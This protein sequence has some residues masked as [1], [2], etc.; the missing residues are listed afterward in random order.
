MNSSTTRKIV[1]IDMDAFYASVEQR[2]N[3]ALRGKPI[4]V[5][6]GG[7]RGVTTTASYEARQFGVRSAMPG[8]KA[9]QL[10]PEL[11]F[12]PPRF[13][14]YQEVSRQVRA[15]FAKYTDLI[16]PLSLDEA[17]LDVTVNKKN[18]P[19]GMDVAKAIMKQVEEETQLTCSAGV[20]YCKFLAKVASGFKKPN[21]LTIIRPKDAEAFLE[22]LPVKDFFGVGKVTAAKMEKMD[23]YTGADLKKVSQLELARRFGKMGVFYYNI[24]R[25]IDNRPVNPSR[26]RKSLGVERTLNKDLGTLDE[27]KPVLLDI[28]DKFCERL[29]KADNYGRTLTLKL[30]TSNFQTLT[31]SKS[32]DYYIKDKQEISQLA[33]R[34]LRENQ[35]AFDKIRLIGLTASNLEKEQEDLAGQQL[36]F[37]WE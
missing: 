18:I 5:G 4:A 34:L 9:K 24:V 2:D 3:P 7:K 25:G 11:I 13:D 31:R 27:I 35:T 30:K 14:V 28:I 8:Y 19:Y 37:D 16:E 21:G 23:I 1:H 15:I 36:R 20:S 12:V 33:L 32:K 10:C 26:V 29:G 22:K 6:G 17:F